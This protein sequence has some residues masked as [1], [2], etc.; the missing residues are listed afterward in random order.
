MRTAL[1]TFILLVAPPL[2]AAQPK[3]EQSPGAAGDGADWWIVASEQVEVVHAELTMALHGEK[4]ELRP[5]LE[6]ELRRIGFGPV[7]KARISFKATTAEGAPTGSGLIEVELDRPLAHRYRASYWLSPGFPEGQVEARAVEI[8]GAVLDIPGINPQLVCGAFCTRC[9]DLIDI[10][11]YSC[12]GGTII[13][14]CRCS[15]TGACVIQCYF[16]S[17]GAPIP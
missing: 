11:G 14:E 3:V 9:H 12:E 2:L 1:A 10:I 8:E 4:L 7:R 6:L 16:S 5:R 13:V 17:A 15:G